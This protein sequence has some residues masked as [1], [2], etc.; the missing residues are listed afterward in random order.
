[1]PWVNKRQMKT[2]KQILTDYAKENNITFKNDDD[3]INKTMDYMFDF[4]MPS[5]VWVNYSNTKQF[6]DETYYL[7]KTLLQNYMYDVIG[8]RDVDRFKSRLQNALRILLPYYNQILWSEQWPKMFIENPAANTDYKEIYT[9]II[10]A[11]EDNE[12]TSTSS[13]NSNSVTGSTQTNSESS[14]SV[15]DNRG[16]DNRTTGTKTSSTSNDSSTNASTNKGN[17]VDNDYP[18]TEITAEEQELIDYGNYASMINTSS[19]S[20]SGTTTNESR[21]A[22]SVDTTDSGSSESNTTSKVDGTNTSN[23]NTKTQTIDSLMSKFNENRKN[24]SNENYEF[25]RVGN[26][27]IQTPGE[28]FRKTRQAFINTIDLLIHDKMIV[29]LFSFLIYDEEDEFYEECYY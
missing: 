2:V 3:L 24:D 15:T 16:T 18:K 27:G 17:S 6:G 5:Y 20:S 4:E 28:V 10:K 1:M 29:K 23:S 13:N 19:G 12:N 22:T 7:K 14:N 25:R 26:I 9:R 11:V 21:Q 8:F